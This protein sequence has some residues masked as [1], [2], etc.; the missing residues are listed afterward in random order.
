MKNWKIILGITGV[1]LLG[2]V[3]GALV[4]YRIDQKRLKMF[5]RGGP[6]ANEMIV[7]RLGNELQLTA[8][9]RQQVLK[10]VQD[11]QFKLREARQKP[12]PKFRLI[13][14]DME[15]RIRNIL[16]PE[17]QAKYDVLMAERKAKWQMLLPPPPEGHRF[18]GPRP[19]SPPPPEPS[20]P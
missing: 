15:Q 10:I 11:T 9:Q 12:D 2:M 19:P 18:R 17:Q 13:L 14:Q 5:L 8:D 6:M 4:M 16:T 7:R 20:Q 1:F 3:A